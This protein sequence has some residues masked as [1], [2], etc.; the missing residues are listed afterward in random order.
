MFVW[1]RDNMLNEQ[2]PYHQYLRGLLPDVQS[3]IKERLKKFDLV[4]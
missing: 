4:A 2:G 1:I 3:H